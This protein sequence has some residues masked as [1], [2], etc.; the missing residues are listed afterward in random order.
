LPTDMN[1]GQRKAGETNVHSL[2]MLGILIA[3]EADVGEW[4]MPSGVEHVT[5]VSNLTRESSHTAT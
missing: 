2:H 1:D 5:C 4:E 3:I